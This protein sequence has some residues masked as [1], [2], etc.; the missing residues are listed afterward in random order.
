M[1]GLRP[2]RRP[3]GGRWLPGLVVVLVV[4]GAGTWQVRHHVQQGEFAGD[5]WYKGRVLVCQHPRRCR[6]LRYPISTHEAV[7]I[8][9]WGASTGKRYSSLAVDNDGRFGSWAPP[10]TYTV[11][12]APSRLSGVPAETARITITA[13]RTV[14]FDL[15][16]GRQG[17]HAPVRRVDTSL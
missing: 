5:G 15:T 7:Y 3:A 14:A 6:Q 12:L 13:G 17:Q 8:V 16:Y 4:I 1:G 11:T 9:L 10:G 2:G